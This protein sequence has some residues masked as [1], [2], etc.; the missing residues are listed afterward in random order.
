MGWIRSY[1]SPPTKQKTD[2]THSHNQTNPELEPS[3]KHG[4]EPLQPLIPQPNRRLHSWWRMVVTVIFSW[5]RSRLCYCHSLSETDVLLLFFFSFWN[6]LPILSAHVLADLL[7]VETRQSDGCRFWPFLTISKRKHHLLILRLSYGR[8]TVLELA[9]SFMI[10]EKKKKTEVL[11][12]GREHSNN[13][14]PVRQ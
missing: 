3:Q 4:L 10:Q 1:L 13:Q 2:G 12:V 14:N 9:S 11:L 6:A 8:R 5:K 7:S